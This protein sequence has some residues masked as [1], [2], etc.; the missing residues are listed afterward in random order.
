METNDS[1]KKGKA[2]EHLIISE[3]LKNDFDVFVP[4]V[5][6]GTDLIIRNKQGGFVEIQVKSRN[7]QGDEGLF[8]M[9]DFKPRWNFFIVCHN[10]NTEDFFCMPSEKFY[11]KSELSKQNGKDVRVIRNKDLI[12]HV[13]C[14]N[15]KGMALLK[16]A[17]E[18]PENQLLSSLI[19]E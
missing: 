5:D 3:L 9:K 6:D 19:G 7:I 14:K 2:I 12:K 13:W 11:E 15:N 16:K 8:F 17:L 10:L 18:D 1:R 4:V